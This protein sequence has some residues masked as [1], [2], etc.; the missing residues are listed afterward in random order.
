[1]LKNTNKINTLT[2]LRFFAAFF[3]ILM[4]SNGAFFYSQTLANFTLIQGVS[5]FFV[6]SGFILTYVYPTLR[7]Q[8]IGRFIKAR[9]A[10]L[11]PA[12]MAGLSLIF[13]LE[14]QYV[15]IRDN[16]YYFLVAASMFG[17]WIP[18]KKWFGTF[19]APSW[20]IGVEV[21][22][23]LCFPL[24]IASFSRTWPIKLIGAGVLV[25]FIITMCNTSHIP[26]DSDSICTLTM[27]YYH[28]LSRLFEFALGMCTALLFMKLAKASSISFIQ[29][30]LFEITCLALLVLS[31]RYNYVWYQYVFG[32]SPAVPTGGSLWVKNSGGS[33]FFIAMLI[34][35]L[36]W[37]K[38]LISRILCLPIFLLLGEMSYSMYLTHHTFL[39]FYGA[40][41]EWLVNH[42]NTVE[43][44]SL[45]WSFILI[46]SYLIWRFIEVPCR[47]YIVNFSMPRLFKKET[48]Q[49]ESAL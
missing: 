17:S 29:A 41:K 2:S 1:M 20:S 38:G 31:L 25:L 49:A 37:Q 39:S 45:F 23:Y 35:G 43:I 14:P 30:S 44:Y 12:H 6:L 16:I 4:H 47:R 10:R 15:H 3:I 40:H 34:L 26:I 18:L 36:A 46:T 33:C 5:I 7:K 48:V 11:W 22:F 19:N 27:V 9:F 13:I 32:T 24:L 21:F 28:P 42:M 8:D